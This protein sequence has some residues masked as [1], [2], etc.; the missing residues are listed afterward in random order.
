MT[1]RIPREIVY[2]LQMTHMDVEYGK[3]ISQKVLH[4]TVKNR[5]DLINVNVDF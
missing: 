4:K 2:N 1:H 5:I 3:P